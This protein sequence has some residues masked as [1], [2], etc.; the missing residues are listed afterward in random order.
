MIISCKYIILISSVWHCHYMNIVKVLLPIKSSN[1]TLDQLSRSLCFKLGVKIERMM[2][3]WCV[4]ESFF[5][6]LGCV[7]LQSSTR[8]KHRAGKQPLPGQCK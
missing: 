6:C 8:E 3:Y 4:C 1:G 5:S 7:F 2:V